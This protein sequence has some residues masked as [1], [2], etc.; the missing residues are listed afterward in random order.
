MRFVIPSTDLLNNLQSL[1]KVIVVKNP[2]PALETFLF[3][4]KGKEL[5]I[6]ASDLDTTL[7]TVIGLDTAEGSGMIG[8]DAKRLLNTIKEFHE[9]LTFN[10][11]TETLNFDIISEKGKYSLV[12]ISADQYP[13]VSQQPDI[14][15]ITVTMTADVFVT[16]INNTLFAASY[17]EN[18]P[19][20]TGI[21]FGLDTE[22]MV[23]AAS[24]SHRLVRYMRTDVKSEHKTSLVLPRKPAGLLKTLLPKD[25]TQI[26]LVIS[27]KNAI[28]RF[29]T[30]TLICRLIEGTYPNFEG[31]IP[32][33]H[34]YRLSVDKDVFSSILKRVS[35]YS[36]KAIQLIKLNMSATELEISAQDIDFSISAHEC[37]NCTYEGNEMAI[38]LKGS[39]LL[40]MLSIM[41]V[42]EVKM[43]LAEPSQAALLAPATNEN[44]NEDLLMLLMPIKVEA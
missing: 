16:A 2:L 20:M 28:I 42:Q 5:T 14:D 41:Q 8:I 25:D 39:T 30:I 32:R 37:M 35:L 38:G 44:E 43:E 7:I 27:K 24:D 36:N 23:V 21:Y 10:I 12:G 4:L 1:M 18:R 3:E 15:S 31:I 29:S 9:P 6:T 34:P 40:E 26:E 33:N 13:V 19:I 17:D 11:D 22:R